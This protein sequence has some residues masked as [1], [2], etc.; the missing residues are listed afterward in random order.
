MAMVIVQTMSSTSEHRRQRPGLGIIVAILYSGKIIVCNYYRRGRLRPGENDEFRIAMN[1]IVGR[2]FDNYYDNNILCYHV[3]FTALSPASERISLFI[4]CP[5]LP[6]C[7]RKNQKKK[8][9][10]NKLR[11]GRTM[12]ELKYRIRII[13]EQN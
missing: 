13:Q 6:V 4:A 1:P 12:I 2:L 7:L 10:I 8:I 9:K 5:S 11:S 3:E